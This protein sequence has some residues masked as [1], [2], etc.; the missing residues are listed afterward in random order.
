MCVTLIVPQVAPE[1]PAP[2][3]VQSAPAFAASLTTLAAKVRVVLVLMVAL[4][5]T[6]LTA[7]APGGAE[8]FRKLAVIAE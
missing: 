7:M 3:S 2:V 1:Q 8:P 5:G 6:T 4:L